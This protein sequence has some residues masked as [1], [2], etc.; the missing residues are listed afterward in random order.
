MQLELEENEASLVLRIVRNRLGELRDEVRHNK[1]S[2]M[3]SYLKHKVRILDR[4]LGKFPEL[5]EKAHM[6]GY[7]I[8][9]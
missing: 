8:P 9:E 2:E 7:I 3:R 4:V 5:D 6:R 1:D